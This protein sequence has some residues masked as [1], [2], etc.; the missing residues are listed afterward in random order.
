MNR[1][2]VAFVCV[3]LVSTAVFAGPTLTVTGTGY[4][5]SYLGGYAGEIKVN[6]SG[7]PNVADGAFITFC[8]EKT[9]NI[10][11]NSYDAVGNIEAIGGGTN[12]G[13]VG[14]G[15]G[16]MLSGA[17]A[18]IYDKYLSGGLGSMTSDK[19]LGLQVAVWALEEEVAVP[20]SGWAKTY[21]DDA[22][23]N[24]WS[25]IGNIRALNLYA[26]NSDHSNIQ[27]WRQDVLCQVIPIPAPGAFA[28]A[29]LG[30]IPVS[31]LRRKKL[32]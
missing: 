15:G 1:I 23:A 5:G 30:I 10:S 18:Y 12:T 19:A 24:A 20:T 2:F 17:T 4:G 7:I 29:S 22:I 32:A 25:G 9:E 11:Y 14:P 21:Y 28:L 16:D 8:I 6:S 26:L 3:S 31:W 27:N 13:P